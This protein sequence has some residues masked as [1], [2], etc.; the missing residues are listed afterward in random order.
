MVGRLQAGLAAIEAVL[1]EGRKQ[2]C[3]TDPE[4]R[5]MGG[6]R[7]RKVR[8][9]Y[10]LEVAVDPAAGLLVV[11]QVS[12]AASDNERLAAVVAAA[13]AHEPDG[14]RAVTADS[15]FYG[16]GAVGRLLAAGI[17]TCVPDSN[18]AGDLHRGQPVGTVRA[19]G[20]GQ[21]AFEYEAAADRYRCPE[22]NRL[23]RHQSRQQGGQEWTVYKARHSCRGCPRARECLTQAGAQYRTLKVGEFHEAVEAARQRFNDPGHQERYRHRGEWVETVFGVL[24]GTLGYQRFLLRGLERVGREARLMAIG[25]QVRKIHAAGAGG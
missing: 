19:A 20:R 10:S 24:R 23:E 22:G 16:G 11:G 6:G 4:A 25:Y 3:L 5:M 13:V 8:E 2:L 17:D 9:C 7:E 18:T 15:G 14:V 21:V 1:A 12:Q